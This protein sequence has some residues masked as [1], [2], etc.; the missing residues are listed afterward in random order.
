MLS[1]RR[2]ERRSQHNKTTTR[3]NEMIIGVIVVVVWVVSAFVI[4]YIVGSQTQP[5][6]VG[7]ANL[8]GE[9]C[10]VNIEQWERRRVETC[11]AKQ[12]VAV[13]QG[14]VSSALQQ[15]LSASAAHLLLV[16]AAAAAALI[17]I[18]GPIISIGLAIA[19]VAAFG[20]VS[21]SLGQ[22]VAA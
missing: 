2:L 4:G 1:V 10:N 15:F 20:L 8:P 7:D 6:S 17:P 13:F 9:G 5:S 18:V 22:L 14:R 19:A 12:Q 21:A 3:R 11:Q 16:V